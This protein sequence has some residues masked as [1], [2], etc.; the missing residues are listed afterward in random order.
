MNIGRYLQV[1]MVWAVT[2]VYLL[3]GYFCITCGGV[4]A[5][6]GAFFVLAGIVQL[7]KLFDGTS[8]GYQSH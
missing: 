7:K 1:I 2:V 5:L 4:M 8:I 3:A 6:I